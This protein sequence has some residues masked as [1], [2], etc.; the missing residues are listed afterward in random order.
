MF[1]QCVLAFNLLVLPKFRKSVDCPGFKVWDL[2][3]TC[4]LLWPE[5]GQDEIRS[6]RF[7]CLVFM[8]GI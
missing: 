1:G 2:G 4:L 7:R 5:V 8:F 6:Q 3:G